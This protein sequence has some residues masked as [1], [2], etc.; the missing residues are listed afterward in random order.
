[1]AIERWSPQIWLAQLANE[2]GLS[3]DLALLKEELKRITPP[4]NVVLDLSGVTQ[5]T[6]SNLSQMLRIRQSAVDLGFKLILCGP[7]SG[8]WGVFLTTGLDKVFQFA[9]DV[10]TALATLQLN[11]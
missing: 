11:R 2:P 5:I 4:P 10:T 9:P 3:E 1:M 8:V 6:S 7:T